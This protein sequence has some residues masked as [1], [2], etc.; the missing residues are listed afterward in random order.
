[1]AINNGEIRQTATDSQ[2]REVV[3]SIYYD[4][5]APLGDQPLVNGP[6]GFCLDLTN[7]SGRNA[8]IDVTLPNGNTTTV[9]VGQGNPVT[10]GPVN[11]RSR[12]AAQMAALGFT[13]RTDVAGLSIG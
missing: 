5:T 8:R 10:G 13:K 2:G 4:Q 6:R 3:M 1:M 9:Q 11:G 12:T 7:V